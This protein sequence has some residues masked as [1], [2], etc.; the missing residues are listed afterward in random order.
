MCIRSK[1]FL[2]NARRDRSTFSNRLYYTFM[3]LIHLFYKM[4][5]VRSI[6]S[7]NTAEYN[8]IRKYICAAYRKII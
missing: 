1:V 4:N 5:L 3:Y 7:I 2:L 6:N 8:S